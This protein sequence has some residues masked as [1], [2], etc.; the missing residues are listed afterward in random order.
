[1]ETKKI[2]VT[3]GN[4]LV[5]ST[6]SADVRI[7]REIDLRDTAYVNTMYQLHKP[8]HVVHC[9][10]KVGGVGGNM[11]FKADY[12]YDNIMMNTNVIEGARKHGVSKLVNFLSVCVF[13]DDV[14]YPLTEDKIHLGQPHHSNN[15]YAY[16]KRM[17]DIQIMAYRE[18]YGINYTSVIPTNIF[19]PRDNFSLIHGHVIPM[20]IHKLYLAQRDNTDFTVW[21]SGRSRREFIFSKDLGKMVDFVLNEYTEPSPV[22]LSTSEEISIKEVVDILVETF[23]FKGNVVFDTTKP[24]GQYR[25]PSDNSKIKSYMPDFKFTPFDVAI[26]ETVEW[27]MHNYE[28]AR[29]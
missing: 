28:S 15:A 26:K 9:A 17:S 19:G 11:S 10:A 16:A 7:G 8:T 20:L 22:I 3:G 2:L 21:G 14:T 1:M 27:F 24:E 25:R 29:K 6:L 23:N 12:F 13:P 4:G 18:Q 5:G